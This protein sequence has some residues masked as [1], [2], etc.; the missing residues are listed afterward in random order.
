[1]LLIR[2]SQVLLGYKKRGLGKGNYMGIGGKVE[3]GETIAQAAIRKVKEEIFVDVANI[4]KVGELSFVFPD[5]PDWS[6]QVHI[7]TSS[8]WL[9]EI[10]ESGEIK[11]KW[12]MTNDLPLTQMWADA[13]FWLQ[14]VLNGHRL[15]GEFTYNADLKVV[16]SWA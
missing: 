16:R 14:A 3:S 2:D 11:P 6:Q 8:R 15:K 10:G 7:F 12:F 9:G 5:K 4:S 13:Q 1:M